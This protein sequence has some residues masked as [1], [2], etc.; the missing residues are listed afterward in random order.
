M[1]LTSRLT[2]RRSGFTLVE[3]L[4]V[5]AIIVIL[6]AISVGGI[7]RVMRL[8][9]ES[10]ARVQ[11]SLLATA[12]DSYKATYG[13]YPPGTGDS[14]VLRTE[15]YP[16]QG[17]ADGDKVFLSHLAPTNSQGWGRS[18]PVLDP[19][20]NLVKN[21]DPTKPDDFSSYQYRSPGLK[22]VADFDLWSFGA[23]GKDGTPDDITNWTN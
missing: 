18:G 15:L 13:V 6:M 19:F 3:L 21:P 5:M 14:T 9:D 8:R 11:I 7:Q 10:K 20:K 17:A 2:P 22:N 23:D 16:A 12:L 4:V 1:K